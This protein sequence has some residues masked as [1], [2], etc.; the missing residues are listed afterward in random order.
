MVAIFLMQAFNFLTH[1]FSWHDTTAIIRIFPIIF[2]ALYFGRETKF[3]IAIPLL[4]ILDWNLTPR[5]RGLVLLPVLTHP[6]RLLLFAG[7][8]P[9]GQKPWRNLH[10]L[11]NRQRAVN[12]LP[13]PCP[14]PSGWL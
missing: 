14:K 8:I 1:G 11:R 9:A 5:T 4:A 3:N 6:N 2:G 12:L 7:K 13:T 10:R